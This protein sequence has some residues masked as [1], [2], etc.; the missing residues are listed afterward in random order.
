MFQET[1]W[2]AFRAGALSADPR[3]EA[4]A[5]WYAKDVLG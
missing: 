1:L 5:S 2:R 3:Y 4:F